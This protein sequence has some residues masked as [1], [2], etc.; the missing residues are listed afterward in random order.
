M[1]AS[2]ILANLSSGTQKQ[3]DSLIQ[4]NIV[5]VFCGL[6]RYK[7]QQIYEQAIW[8]LANISGDGLHF[9]N[10]VYASSCVLLLC[11]LYPLTEFKIKNL[12]IWLFSNLTR[13]NQ[14]VK[15]YSKKISKM[16]RILITHFVNVQDEVSL[17]ECIY[18]MSQYASGPYLF[19]Y[20]SQDLFKKLSCYYS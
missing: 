12:I 2:W 13:I 10:I 20:Q 19:L 1:E 15:K 6:L 5:E 4:K 17:K 9:R 8:G 3:T 11:E 7:Y 16:L 18:G 14:D